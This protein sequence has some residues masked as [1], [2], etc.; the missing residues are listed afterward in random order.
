MEAGTRRE[1]VRRVSLAV[2]AISAPLPAVGVVLS[3]SGLLWAMVP[4]T[5][6]VVTV[7]TMRA[8]PVPPPAVSAPPQA[9]ARPVLVAQVLPVPACEPGPDL[10]VLRALVGGATAT[11][12][13]VV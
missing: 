4:T 2:M 7:A 1:R 13:E 5:A 3:G 6:G 9:P 11:G 8:K 10:T 12:R